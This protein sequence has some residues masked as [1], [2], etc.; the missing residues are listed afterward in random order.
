M[1]ME[2]FC[3]LRHNKVLFSAHTF[4]ATLS[5]KFQEVAWLK[6]MEES[7][8]S[9]VLLLSTYS[10][11]FCLPSLPKLDSTISSLWEFWWVFVSMILFTFL[12]R[13]LYC[14][15]LWTCKLWEIEKF[16][17]KVVS[18]GLSKHNSLKKTNTLAYYGVMF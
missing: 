7:G 11:L 5:P 12:P 14:K 13:A 6:C 9:S 1:K 8:S 18:S 3:G 15:T 16:C 17:S 2:P 10:G 4:G